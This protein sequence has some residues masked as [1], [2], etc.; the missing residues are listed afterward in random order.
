MDALQVT[1]RGKR[2]LVVVFDC[3]VEPDIVLGRLYLAN[4][5]CVLQLNAIDN[6]IARRSVVCELIR[7][8]L[9]IVGAIPARVMVPAMRSWETVTLRRSC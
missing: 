5:P 7:C 3:G 4:E 9:V 6:G 2:G 1:M 8:L